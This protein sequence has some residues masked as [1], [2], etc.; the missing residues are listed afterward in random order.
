VILFV[1][2]FSDTFRPLLL[3]LLQ[4][5]NASRVQDVLEQQL[6]NKFIAQQADIKH[7]APFFFAVYILRNLIVS[8]RGFVQDR[9]LGYKTVSLG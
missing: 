3:D 5:E 9:S 1:S 8:T 7:Y 4:I 6:T 2:Y